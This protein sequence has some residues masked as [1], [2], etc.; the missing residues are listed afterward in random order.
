[1]KTRY[2]LVSIFFLAT[3]FY[4]TLNL[5]GDS[6]YKGEPSDHFDGSHFHNLYKEGAETYLSTLGELATDWQGLG[7]WDEVKNTVYAIPETRVY[8]D[9]FKVTFINHSTAL[10]QTS[11]LNILTDPIW[12]DY[13]GPYPLLSPSRYRPPG[14]AFDDLPP[15]DVVVV[16]HSHYDHMDLATLKRL[17]DR[18]HP[19]I[20]VGLG[21]ASLLEE[22]GIT[23]VKEL[24]WWSSFHLG[25]GVDVIG[26]PAQHW[27][28]RGVVD[29]DKRLWLGFLFNTAHGKYYFAGDTAMGPHFKMLQERY[30]SVRVALLPIG[31]FRPQ[32]IMQ[33]SHLSPDQALEAHDILQ[34]KVSIAIHYGTFRLGLDGQYEAVDRLAA[35]LKQRNS[36]NNPTDFRVLDFG[37][38]I[39]LGGGSVDD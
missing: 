15:I 5:W 2:L 12:S 13:S 26:V 9:S 22:Q 39:E 38:S 35:L 6:V 33:R 16:S 37:E 7:P 32:A 36:N 4:F 28:R 1:M 30:G 18:F 20:F 29:K 17:S 23:Q 27:S 10:I 19:Q 31:A 25:Q 8:G 34:S 14:V 24:D 11:G 3:S 21:N